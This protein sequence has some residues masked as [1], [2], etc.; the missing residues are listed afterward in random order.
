MDEPA[1]TLAEGFG[2]GHRVELPHARAGHGGRSAAGRFRSRAAWSKTFSASRLVRRACRAASGHNAPGALLASR[3]ISRLTRFMP[4]EGARGIDRAGFADAGRG[5]HPVRQAVGH[6]QRIG[7]A[8]RESRHQ[9]PVNAQRVGKL[10]DV[11]GPVR[12]APARLNAD[13]PAPGRSGAMTRTATGSSGHN[14][15]T[16]S[17]EPGRPWNRNSDGPAAGPYSA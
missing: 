9:E 1:D 15:G 13:A 11:A 3:K 14:P 4:A 6:G 10:A 8:G 5:D 7:A 12:Q 2:G 16:F 17:G